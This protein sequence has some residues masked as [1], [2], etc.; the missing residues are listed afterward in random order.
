NRGVGG[1]RSG[2]FAHLMLQSWQ[3]EGPHRLDGCPAARCAA[4]PTEVTAR[5]NRGATVVAARAGRPPRRQGPAGGCD[6]VRSWCHPAPAV[7]SATPSPRLTPGR[8]L[9]GAATRPHRGV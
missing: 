5:P 6:R 3:A 4:L 8:G 1:V 9:L 7:T 2:H